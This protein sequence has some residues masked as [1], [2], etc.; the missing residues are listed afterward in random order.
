MLSVAS[1]CIPFCLMVFR[2]CVFD[3]SS[4]HTT[5]VKA[6]ECKCLWFSSLPLPVMMSVAA[7]RPPVILTACW[8]LQEAILVSGAP[9]QAQHSERGLGLSRRRERR[10]DVKFGQAFVYSRRDPRRGCEGLRLLRRTSNKFDRDASEARSLAPCCLCWK[11]RFL[12]CQ[13]SL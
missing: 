13:T 9:G 6:I 3:E 4:L 12:Y 10:Q 7:Q 8:G 2:V 5:W 1:L 11:P